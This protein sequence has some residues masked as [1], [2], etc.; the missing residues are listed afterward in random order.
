M[1]SLSFDMLVFYIL[2]FMLGVEVKAGEPL[3]VTP[4]LDRIIHLSQVCYQTLF[5]LLN[6]WQLL[7]REVAIYDNFSY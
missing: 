2:Y 3:K 7:Y 5:D 6:I 1:V 4:E